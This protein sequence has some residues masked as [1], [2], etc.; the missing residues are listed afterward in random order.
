M[1]A[2]AIQADLAPYID[3]ATLVQLTDDDR[4]GIADAPVV[5]GILD[6][7]SARI[8]AALKAAG[9]TTPV[10]APGAALRSLTARLSLAALY[11]RRP[12]VEAPPSITTVAEAAEKE[13]QL[14][15]A[16]K[17]QPPE[18]IRLSSPTGPSGI[19]T[20]TDVARNWDDAELF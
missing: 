6:D 8:D 9:Y 10:A 15:G 7:V 20:S 11:G 12:A 3:G 4:N 1:A 14:I 19:A 13:L 5:T 2:Y 17:V 18:A 16:G